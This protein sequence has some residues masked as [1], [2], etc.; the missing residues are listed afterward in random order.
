MNVNSFSVRF[1]Q[2]CLVLFSREFWRRLQS[3][4]SLIIAKK[5]VFFGRTMCSQK[6]KQFRAYSHCV[7]GDE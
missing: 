3:L 6:G 2:K 5:I 4:G 7:M 1:K